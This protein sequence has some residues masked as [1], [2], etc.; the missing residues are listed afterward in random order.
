MTSLLRVAA[1]IVGFALAMVGLAM[2]ATIVMWPLGVLFG[3]GGVALTLTGIF[4]PNPR[5]Q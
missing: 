3:L 2:T 1:V 5:T 4:I